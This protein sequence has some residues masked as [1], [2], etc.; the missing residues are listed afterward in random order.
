MSED[1]QGLLEKINRDGIEKAE[2]S[3]A[4]IIAEAKTKAAEIVKAANDETKRTAAEAQASAKDFIVRAEQ[5]VAQASRDTI[6]NLKDSIAK[7]LE[8]VLT[9]NID[10]ALGDPDVAASLAAAAIEQLAGNA[11]ISAP[12]KLVASLKAQLSAKGN[13][14]VLADGSLNSGFSVKIDNGR[15]EH[16]FT[17]E[18]V[19]EEL[20]KRLRPEIAKLLK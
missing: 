13:I 3:A 14:E 1:L 9:D 8:R 7:L 19:A 5:A 17:A 6:I 15:V 18:V 20:S 16:A 11:V 10:K 2:A 12:E 4:V